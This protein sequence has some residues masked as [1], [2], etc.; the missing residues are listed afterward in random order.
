MYTPSGPRRFG[1]LEIG[2]R[3]CTPN[4]VARVTNIFR[5]G[6]KP[7]FRLILNDG[8]STRATGDHR[9]EFIHSHRGSRIVTTSEVA[10]WARNHKNC[11]HLPKIKPVQYEEREVPVDPWLVGFLIGDGCISQTNAVGFSTADREIVERVKETVAPQYLVTEGA[12][13]SYSYTLRAAHRGAARV[14]SRGIRHKSGGYEVSLGSKYIGRFRNLREAESAKATAIKEKYGELQIEKSMQVLLAEIGLLGKRA[15]EKRIPEIYRYN[16]EHVRL[17]VLRGILDSDAHV[18][19]AGQI[20]LDQTSPELAADVQELVQGLGGI[21]R[22]TREDRQDGRSRPSYRLNIRHDKPSSLVWL[23]RKKDRCK[24]GSSRIV[25][26]VFDVVPDGVAEVQCIEIDTDDALYLTDN[27]IPTHNTKSGKSQGCLAWIFEQAAVHGKSER[28]YWWV[29][30][31]YS[32]AEIMFRR[33]R[34]R[35]PKELVRSN[36]SALSLTLANGA[37]ITFK[38]GER[39]DDLYGEDVYAAVVD[40]ASRMR[41]ESWLA[42]R[43]TLTATNGPVRIIGNVKGRK[44][45]FY[46]LARAAEAGEQDM[47]YHRI[48]AWDAVEAGVLKREEIEASLRDFKRLGR[49]G[50]W[51]QL[52]LAEAGEDGDNPFGLEAIRSCLVPNFSTERSYAA[53]VDLAGRGAVN[54][55]PASDTIDRDYTAIVMFDRDGYATEITRFRKPH[56]ETEEEIAQ[57]VGRTNALVDSTGTGDAIVER[58]Q[59]RGNMR[60]DGF[61]FTTKSRQDLLEG[62]ALA[63]GEEGIHFPDG[64]LRSE[65]ESFE[66]EYTRTGV[67]YVAPPGMHDDLVFAAALAVKK[68]PWKRKSK[69]PAPEGITNPAGSKWVDSSGESDAW[70]KYQEG[71]KPTQMGAADGDAVQTPVVPMP[72]VVGGSGGSR[73]GGADR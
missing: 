72:F 39:S 27:A 5:F 47:A 26:K 61:T 60:V 55:N 35:I 58:L 57:V 15:H 67:R 20:V 64:P 13:G 8:T 18:S 44:N 41:E 21:A 36:Q 12:P 51:K 38:S 54:L 6:V 25:R 28:N 32:Q 46:T 62:L 63:I 7:V 19:S 37:R 16:S 23:K 40:E 73:W 70:K 30:P 22:L 31:V 52:Y 50:A 29:A 2:D 65:L 66:F 49:E 56:T 33:L 9:W 14:R 3:V 45:W 43:S 10:G 53:G 59:R 69:A 11:W 48:T 1:D 34:S 17:E 71:K 24:D 42:L 68:L 4:G